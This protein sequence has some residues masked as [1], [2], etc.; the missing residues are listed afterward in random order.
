[1]QTAVGK[2]G[3][4]PK[5]RERSSGAAKPTIRPQGQPHTKPHSKTGRCI[6]RSAEPIWGICPVRKGRTKASAK[7]SAEK[8]SLRVVWFM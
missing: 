5:Q 3:G 4:M 8:T 6:G 7:K 2:K 1:M